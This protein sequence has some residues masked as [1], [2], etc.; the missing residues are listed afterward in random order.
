[1]GATD[2][3][4]ATGIDAAAGGNGGFSV[5]GMFGDMATDWPLGLIRA[6][7]TSR[8]ANIRTRYLTVATPDD[9]RIIAPRLSA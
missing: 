3:G 5:A 9:G 1:M 6:P 8:A 7:A 2:L 4:F